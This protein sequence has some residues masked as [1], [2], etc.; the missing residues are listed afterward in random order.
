[1]KRFKR[2]PLAAAMVLV[3]AAP[4]WAMAQAQSEQTL[5]EVRVRGAQE[6][7]VAPNTSSG[8][9]TDTPLRDIPQFIN[10]VPQEVI[11]QQGATSLSDALRNVPGISYAAPEGG[12]QANFLYYM[13]GFP[14]GGDL[15][16]DQI[17]DLGEYNRDLFNIDQVE[18]LKGPSALMYG[19]GST[20]GIIH[21]VSKQPGLLPHKEAALELG[22]DSKKRLTADLNLK[23]GDSSALR[24][25]LLGE[26]SDYYRYELGQDKIGVAPTFRLGIGGK[27]DVTLSYFYLKTRDV[28]DYGQPTLFT[29]A[30]GFFGIA[31]VSPRQY[32]GFNHYDRTDHDTHIA[33]FKVEHQFDR[34]LAL[35]NTLRWANYQR[36]M[37]STQASLN[38]TDVNGNPVT[39]NTPLELMLANR[40]HNR[41]RDN[42]DVTL[43][44]QTELTWKLE[45]AGIKHTVLGGLELARETLDRRNHTFAGQT[46]QATPLLNPDPTVNMIYT[47]TPNTDQVSQ[48][49]TWA[50][51]LQDQL[52]FSPQWKALLGT[53]FENYDADAR[54]TTVATGAETRFSRRDKMTSY[55][56]GLIWQPSNA[57]SYYVSAGNAYNPSGEL[58]VYGNTATNLNA[59]NDDLGPEE[60]LNYELGS[61]WDYGAT[62]LR[63]ALFRTEKV[64]QRYQDE[65]GVTTLGGR[66][67]VEGLEVELAGDVT[68]RLQVVAAMAF[69]SAEIITGP[70]NTQGKRPFGVPTQSGSLWTNYKL[71]GGWE[72]GGGATWSKEKFL[73]DSN[74]G[75]I[76]SYT[77]WDATVAYVQKKYELRFNIFNIFDEVY[78]YG[79]Y[80][81]SPS[82]VLPGQPRSYYLT[83]RIRFD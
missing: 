5:P 21:Q 37:E 66:R 10:T 51:Y 14:A 71:D 33:T 9:R 56:G 72:T 34:A 61:Q 68:N 35:R 53:R 36:Q 83:T 74:D 52:Q 75:Q 15:F 47:K 39:K 59:T 41:G 54:T 16:L 43:I 73:T 12:T 28:T 42:D 25:N 31:P 23:T 22:T 32:Y 38:T 3:F 65:F 46:T 64:N 18:V 69:M 78:Y 70:A 55:R 19:R 13:R 45:T 63:S 6:P 76:P 50:V 44:N 1:M 7:Y 40:V 29:A 11:R 80:Q 30:T 67:R 77:R 2:R 4:E 17:R 48:G 62:R 82:R 20:G 60:T 26:S 81:N 57:Q 24:L 58:G 79:G 49:D 27:T 8:T